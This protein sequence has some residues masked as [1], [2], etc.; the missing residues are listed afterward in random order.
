MSFLDNLENNLKSL[1]SQEEGKEAAER[2]QRARESARAAAQAAAPWAEE[3]KKGPFTA[4]LLK[5]AAR[6]GFSMRVKVHVAWL[7]TTLRLEARD[8]RLELRP[9]ASGVVA[10]YLEGGVETRSEP[11]DLKSDAGELVRRWLEPAVEDRA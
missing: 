2:S 4:D 10:A 8:R 7:G 9:T 6:I 1:E 3:L 5:Q 11:L